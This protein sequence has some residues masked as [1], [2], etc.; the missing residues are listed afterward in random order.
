VIDPPG[1]LLGSFVFLSNC[2]SGD[3]LLLGWFLLIILGGLVTSDYIC[4]SFF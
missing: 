3:D 1:M 2:F 4:T